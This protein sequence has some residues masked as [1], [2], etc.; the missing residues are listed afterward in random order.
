MCNDLGWAVQADRFEGLFFDDQRFTTM[1]FLLTTGLV[2]AF[3]MAQGW[4][5]NTVCTDPDA[6]N[7]NANEAGPCLYY[8]ASDV[9]ACA[10]DETMLE[11]TNLVVDP[12]GAAASVVQ[13]GNVSH[14]PF[15]VEDAEGSLYVAAAFEGSHTVFGQTLTSTGEDDMYLA[16]LNAED[17]MWLIQGLADHDV[18]VG[19]LAL[20]PDGGVT[21]VGT[22]LAL[23][24][25]WRKRTNYS[26]F[27]SS[28]SGHRDGYD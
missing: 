13:A 25:G 27:T 23:S 2:L 21:V 18:N 15:F 22:H 6:C 5:Q 1:R 4:G 10:G 17:L 20:M 11:V 26:G 3:S 16:K 12:A 14:A 19:D 7:Y 24:H 28:N 9:T 8:T